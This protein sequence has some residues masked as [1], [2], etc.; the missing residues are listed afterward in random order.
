MDGNENNAKQT[1]FFDLEDLQNAIERKQSVEWNIVVIHKDI[2]RVSVAAYNA[3]N[4]NNIAEEH[5]LEAARLHDELNR[6]SQL[7]HLPLHCFTKQQIYDVVKSWLFND[8]QFKKQLRSII[9]IFADYSLFGERIISDRFSMNSI[10]QILQKDLLTFMTKDTFKILMMKIK[11]WKTV[12]DEDILSKSAEQIG[13]L[14][15]H[16]P[17]TCLLKRV[18]H[19]IDGIDGQKLIEYYEQNNDWMRKVTGWDATDIYQIHAVLFKYASF[20][21]SQI[22]ENTETVSRNLW[23]STV[24]LHSLKKCIASYKDM[25]L[26]T[27]AYKIK[28]GSNELHAFSDKVMEAVST[29]MHMKSL[30]EAVADCFISKYPSVLS[31]V[32]SEYDLNKYPSWTCANCSNYNFCN[33]INGKINVN[34]SIC[35]LCGITQ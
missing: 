2:K 14:L 11:H 32:P 31:D 26:Q 18:M 33:F 8:I 19:K 13:Y 16:R 1:A 34:L 6:N 20:S 28:N 24:S 22:N 30:Y 10:R 25:S 27:I 15:H 4:D 21:L 17:V 5:G 3:K 7:Q 23:A 9:N 12:D 35:S 29:G